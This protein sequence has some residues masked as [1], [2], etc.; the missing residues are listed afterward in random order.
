MKSENRQRW[1][2]QYE[3]LTALIESLE[4]E[5]PRDVKALLSAYAQRAKAIDGL[6]ASSPF[7]A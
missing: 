4:A 5:H 6:A 2:N 1:Q 7:G 3:Q